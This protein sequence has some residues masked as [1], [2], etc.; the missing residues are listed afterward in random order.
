MPFAGCRTYWWAE[1]NEFAGSKR[2]VQLPPLVF[3]NASINY[4]GISSLIYGRVLDRTWKNQETVRESEKH[5]LCYSRSS[6]V[7]HS[8]SSWIIDYYIII[9]WRWNILF[10]FLYKFVLFEIL[11]RQREMAQSGFFFNVHQILDECLQSAWGER[12][13]Y[14]ITFW[15]TLT[16]CVQHFKQN[17]LIK[18]T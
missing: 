15:K 16:Q 3:R 4:A 11:Y 1:C 18:E 2:G 17:G 7:R 14:A 8:G 10:V 9:T 12:S 5:S 6:S 13:H